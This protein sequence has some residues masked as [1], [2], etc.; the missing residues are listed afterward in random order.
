LFL[1]SKRLPN[2]ALLA[3]E[4]LMIWWIAGIVV[5]VFLAIGAVVAA[6]S[7]SRP[8]KKGPPLY[9]DADGTPWYPG[10]DNPQDTES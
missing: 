1:F 6:A 5:A 8:L 7:N 9:H 2:A 4:S 3:R 10:G